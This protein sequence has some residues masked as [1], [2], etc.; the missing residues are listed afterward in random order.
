[1]ERYVI[2][3]RYAEALSQV[4]GTKK[5]DRLSDELESF[6]LVLH[7]ISD[8]REYFI[9]PIVPE[10]EKLKVL[11]KIL[12]SVQFM[13]EVDSFF[14][15]LLEK[16]RMILLP[17][18]VKGFREIIQDARNMETAFIRCATQMTEEEIVNIVKKLSGMTSRQLR[19]EVSHDPSLLCGLVAQ[20]GHVIYDMSL[21]SK[22]QKLE[23]KLH[24][25][26]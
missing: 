1:M 22:L 21:K 25:S 15:L 26:K 6:N 5:W 13:P 10:D 9:S 17:E 2:A 12:G 20:V 18:I 3:E 19:A 14:H 16:D 8:L 11:D 4:V 24:R 23:V 7:E